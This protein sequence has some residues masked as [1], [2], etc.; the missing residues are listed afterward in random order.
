MGLY[1]RTGYRMEAFYSF[2]VDDGLG[3]TRDN[4]ATIDRKE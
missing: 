4:S 1:G 2:E 3:G